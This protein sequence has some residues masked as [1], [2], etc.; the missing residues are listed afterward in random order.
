MGDNEATGQP[1][2]IL[3]PI[4][5]SEMLKLGKES[6]DLI[7]AFFDPEFTEGKLSEAMQLGKYGWNI[8]AKYPQLRDKRNILKVLLWVSAG[9]GLESLREYCSYDADG[10]PMIEWDLRDGLGN[11]LLL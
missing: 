9:G 11:P 2:E 10:M 3:P 4:P 5:A 7:Q 8:G 6:Q 1:V